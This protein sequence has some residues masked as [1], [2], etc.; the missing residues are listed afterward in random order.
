LDY[1]WKGTPDW[2]A[3]KNYKTQAG[4]D[5]GQYAFV[6][7]RA[8]AVSLRA[9]G[10]V[11]SYR[12]SHVRIGFDIH[13][14]VRMTYPPLSRDDP[15]MRGVEYVG[16]ET[17][18]ALQL[19]DASRSGRIDLWHLLQAPVGS[20]LIVPLNPNASAY[21]RKPLSYGLAGAWIER[22]DY[23]VWRYGG[24]ARAKFGLAAA[25]LTGRTAILRELTHGHWCLIVREFPADPKAVYGDHPYGVPREDQVFQA[26][27]GYGFGEMEY[28]SPLLDARSGP[29][30]L[31]ESDQLWAFGGSAQAIA[32]LA[33][34]L[35][36]VDVRYLMRA[37]NP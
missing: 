17:S 8:D 4:I 2:Q 12:D 32:V 34:R 1:H 23:I 11:T 9:R 37:R 31:Q 19:D 6:E 22:R 28:H 35:L 30:T 7:A 3:F 10:V 25:A 24:E 14:S 21:Q 18:N 33:D 26:W 13:R 16:I 29:R 27:D 20:I 5:P 15:L 36:G